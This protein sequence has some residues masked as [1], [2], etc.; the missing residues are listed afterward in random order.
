M[1]LRRLFRRTSRRRN[2]PQHVVVRLSGESTSK[3][4][5]RIEEDLRH[6]L[7]SKPGLLEVDLLRVTYLGGDGGRFS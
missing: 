6:A 3:N 1:L 5:G 2:Q 4:T 7:R